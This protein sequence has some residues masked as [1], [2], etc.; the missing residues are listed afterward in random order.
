MSAFSDSLVFSSD[1]VLRLKEATSVCPASNYTARQRVKEQMR[2]MLETNAV[3]QDMF[4]W[5]IL[6]AP[7]IFVATRDS[8]SPTHQHPKRFF[9]EPWM[10][11]IT[12]TF[13]SLWDKENPFGT[14]RSLWPL[15]IRSHQLIHW[16]FTAGLL[17]WSVWASEKQQLLVW[18]AESHNLLISSQFLCKC[19][20]LI[21]T[22]VPLFGGGLLL[23]PRMAR[24][25]FPR[26]TKLAVWCISA[27]C[28]WKSIL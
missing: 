9:E 15:R 17:S 4:L 13:T 26:P 14:Q 2:W 16:D 28:G 7:W 3:F 12:T 20:N 25:I 21:W 27:L 18:E 6:F 23:I 8:S 24:F 5:N 11:R 10:T 1:F 19:F 22:K